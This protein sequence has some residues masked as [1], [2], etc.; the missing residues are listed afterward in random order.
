MNEVVI[1]FYQSSLATHLNQ[2]QNALRIRHYSDQTEK[3]YV[4][5]GNF[6]H[7]W[8]MHGIFAPKSTRSLHLQDGDSL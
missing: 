1:H 4:Y 6:F 3:A 8:K 5:W 7:F 2:L